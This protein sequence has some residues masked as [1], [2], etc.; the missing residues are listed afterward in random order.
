MIGMYLGVAGF[1]LEEVSDMPWRSNKERGK[2][3]V[4]KIKLCEKSG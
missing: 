4:P 1:T 3:G 2:S